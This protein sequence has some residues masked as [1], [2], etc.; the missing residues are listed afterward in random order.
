MRCYSSHKLSVQTNW[1]VSYYIVLCSQGMNASF[2][3]MINV[4]SFH[5]Q[6]KDLQSH[7]QYCVDFLF[8]SLQIMI[9]KYLFLLMLAASASVQAFERDLLWS[10]RIPRSS[11][12]LR[13][14]RQCHRWSQRI[15]PVLRRLSLPQVVLLTLHLNVCC[16]LSHKQ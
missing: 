4:V 16:I 10:R 15:H 12:R 9:C 1:T 6:V 7:G 11:S 13:D 8:S 14:P 5:V 3:Y 2:P